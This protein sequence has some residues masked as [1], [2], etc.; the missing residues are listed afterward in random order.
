MSS[1]LK[2]VGNVL[3]GGLVTAFKPVQNAFAR[4]TTIPGLSQPAPQIDLPP[5]PTA[6][7]PA[8][9]PTGSADQ[10]TK[11]AQ[12]QLSFLTAA[13]KAAAAIGGG[14]GGKSLLGQ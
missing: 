7:P 3:T 6:P 11:L 5:P 12:T 14:S 13:S 9:S 8:Q 2:T 4:A 1:P 10:S